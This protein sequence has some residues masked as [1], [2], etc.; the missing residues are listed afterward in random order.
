MKNLLPAFFTAALAILPLSSTHAALDPKLVSADARWLIHLDFNLLRES[1][2][3]REL[4]ASAAQRQSAKSGDN[5]Q[6]DFQK[7]L[8]TVG[9]ATAYG[10]NFAHNPQ[11]ID[12]TLVLEG[13]ADLRKIAEGYIA[14]AM[15]ST[16]DQFTEVKDLPFEAYSIGNDVFVGFPKEPIILISKVKSQLPRAYEL[17]RG[18]GSSMA[19]APSSP[20]RDLIP[21]SRNAFLVAASVVPPETISAEGGP[22]ARLLK[23]ANSASLSMGERDQL[24]FATIK[25][26]ANSADTADKLQ[27]IVQ[28]LAAMASLAQ[29]SNQDVAEFVKSVAVER[30]DTAVLLKLSYSSERL[31]GMIQNMTREHQQSEHEAREEEPGQLIAEWKADQHL[32]SDATD[33]AGLTVRKIENVHLSSGA[34]IRLSGKRDQGEHARID[35]VEI[36]SSDRALPPLKFEAEYLKLSG[37]TVE[38]ASAASGGKIIRVE[39]GVGVAELQFP[40]AD[41]D[42]TLNIRYLDENDGKSTFTVRVEDPAEA[43]IE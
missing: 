35:Y 1:D 17:H 5:V 25:L 41:G 34:I 36:Q 42:Y 7:V 18:K 27:K 9:K 2:I 22:Q 37:Y 28:G 16:P 10:A 15:L 39:S 38:K 32:G 4:L 24:T 31:S 19:N 14:Q 29:S 33:Q 26:I 13:T 23:M 12:G 3:G 8:A 20:L 6:V 43:A 40:G 21:P 11:E 30:Q